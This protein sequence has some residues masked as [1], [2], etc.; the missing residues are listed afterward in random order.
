MLKALFVLEAAANLGYGAGLLVA[1]GP[2]LSLYG[3]E[4]DRAGTY[5]AQFLGGALVGF[6]MLTWL[7][8]DLA[9]TVARRAII[10][11]LFAASTLGFIVTLL[12]QLAGGANPFGWSLVAL[13]LFF[14]LAWGYFTAAA[15]GHVSA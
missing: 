4:T 15:R 7:V 2:L 11:S 10:A 13:T 3:M 5:L 8:R 12:N 1:S 6:G 14:S 9:D